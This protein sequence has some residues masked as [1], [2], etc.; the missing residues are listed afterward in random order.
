MSD[1]SDDALVFGTSTG[2]PFDPGDVS[3]RAKKAWNDKCEGF[4][5]H[6]C[7]HGFASVCIEAGVNAKRIQ[8][9][10]GHSSITTTFDLYGRLLDRSEADSVEKVDK[11]LVVGPS[12]GPTGAA[13]SGKQRSGKSQ[14][15]RA[16]RGRT[17]AKATR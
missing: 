15:G 6:E 11:Y 4:T 5:L 14:V 10:M 2:G 16:V 13:R 3:K 9:W 8:R 1:P 17:Q 7:R 12:V